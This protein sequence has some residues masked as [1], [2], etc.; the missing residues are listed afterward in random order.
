MS[1]QIF[2]QS[3]FQL[4][5]HVKFFLM[6]SDLQCPPLGKLFGLIVEGFKDGRYRTDF[7][8]VITRSIGNLPTHSYLYNAIVLR[9][10]VHHTVQFGAGH[11]IK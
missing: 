5:F 7:G 2:A 8:Q 4:L 9:W 11:I 10:S 1:I 6:V 3:Y